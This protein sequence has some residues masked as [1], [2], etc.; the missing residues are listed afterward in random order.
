MRLKSVSRVIHHVALPVFLFSALAQGASWQMK[1]RD[2]QHTGRADFVVPTN[3]LNDSFFDVFVWQK[4]SPGG[5][6]DGGFS[7]SSMVFFDGAGPGGVDLV[8]G[9]YHWPKGVQGMDRHTGAAFWAGNPEGGETIGVRTPAFSNDGMTIYVVNDATESAEYPNGHPLMA[10][11]A[12]DGPAFFWHNGNMPEPQRLYEGSPTIDPWGRIYMHSWHERPYGAVDTGASLDLD[13]WTDAEVY[14]EWGSPSIYEAEGAPRVIVAAAGIAQVKALDGSTGTEL[15]SV[16]LPAYPNATPTIDPDNGNIY[17]PA[18]IDRDIYVAGLDS[19]GNPLWSSVSFRVYDYQEGVN[20]GQIATTCGC[21]SHNG[22]TYYF[23]TQS[24]AGDGGLYAINTADGSLKWFFPTGSRGWWDHYSSPIVTENGVIVVGNNDNDTYLAILDDGTEGRLLDAFEVDPGNWHA[25]AS[26][27]LSTDGLLYLPLRTY[28][29]ASNGDG[30]IPTVAIDNV[31]SAFD[32]SEDAQASLSPPPWQGAFALNDAVEVTWQPV[33]DPNGLLDHYAVY[34][35]TAAFQSVEGMTPIATV[36]GAGATEYLD[37]TAENGTAYYYAV[38]SVTDQGLEMR[39]V[40]SVGPRTPFDET[41]L[42]VASIAR[43]PRFPRYWPEYTYY[44]VTEPGGFGPYGFSAATGLSGGQDE[45][46]QRWSN[47]GDTV[48]YRATV[49]NRGTN[50]VTGVVT[51]VWKTDGVVVASTPVYIDLSPWATQAFDLQVQWDGV[52]HEYEFLIDLADARVGNNTLSIWSKSVAFLSFIDRT[53][54]E[55]FREETPGYPN[56]ITNDFIDWL[57]LH[58]TRFNEL[59]AEKDCD[60]RVHFDLL[61]VI[62][63]FSPDPNVNTIEFAIFPFRYRAEEGSLRLSG[64]YDPAEDLDY[65]L[66][67]EMG[68]QLGLI[69]IYQLNLG[70]DQNLVTRDGYSGPACLMNGCSHFLSDHSAN[71]MN[72]WQETAHGYFGQYLYCMPQH[73]K[74][75]LRGIGGTPLTGAAV[76]VYQMCERPGL[77]KVITDQVKFTGT[78]DAQGEWTLPNVAIDPQMV[79]PAFNGD[80]LHDNPFGYVA[81]IGTN[82]VFLMKVERDGFT[83]YCW[84]DITEVNNAYWA[85]QTQTATIERQLLLGGTIQTFPPADMTELN[86]SSWVGWADG[87]W[88]TLSD[89]TVRKQVGNGSVLFETNGGFD[90]YARYPG[91]RL[92]RWDLTR[93]TALRIW[94]YAENENIGFQN[95]SPWI[96]L[97]SAGGYYQYQTDRDILGEAIGRWVE[98]VIP[99]AGDDLWHRTEVGSPD[100]AAVNTIEIHADTWDNGF[101]YWMDGVRFDLDPADAPDGADLPARLALYPASPNPLVEATTIRFDLPGA[102]EIDLGV[103]DVGGRLV[104]RLAKGE[105]PAGRHAVAWDASR[106]ASGVYFIRM[107]AGDEC[108]ERKIVVRR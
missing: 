47:L 30:D 19:E 33:P 50:P 10:F 43:L 36:P 96:R 32:L 41:D 105:M 82:G 84:L 24:E 14:S 103:F 89:D 56:P 38:T 44:E 48:T 68:H 93:R 107:R 46:T 95:L 40:R 15:W 79:P 62:E 81:V 29:V 104:A 23:Q 7:A 94:S 85:G 86:A 16:Q 9:A 5:G 31:F 59:F 64:Y 27:T 88:A 101:R 100:L 39:T 4:P 28:W 67:H 17:V 37:A 90:T 55:A 21:L 78:T 3:R 66:L 2:M 99:L 25:R 98:F 20:N 1:Q 52:N 53:R 77:G 49:R 80:E 57:N 71:A 65:G 26:A 97:K 54:M 102:G 51:M 8:V 72:H 83:D 18:E 75:R 106:A 69:D 92:A 61:E 63:D 70:P 74:M 13:W 108:L 11:P 35:D 87:G 91:D 34:R 22:E 45:N 76:T 60:K 42:Q 12:T 73:V 6:N 58:M